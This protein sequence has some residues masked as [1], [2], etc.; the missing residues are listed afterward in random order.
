MRDVS[1]QG[2]LQEF[3]IAQYDGEHIVE[4]MGHAAGELSNRIQPMRLP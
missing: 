3:G 1:L 4:V 2:F